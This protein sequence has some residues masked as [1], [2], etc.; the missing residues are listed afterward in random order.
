MD[1]KVSESASDRVIRVRSTLPIGLSLDEVDRIY[2]GIYDDHNFTFVLHRRVEDKEVEGTN[3]CLVQVSKPSDGELAIEA[4]AD[5]R[6]RGGA[7]EALHLMNL[8][9]GLHEKTGLELKA[10]VF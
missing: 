9:L 7:G 8:L 3:K 1:I 4:V 10:S 2:E 6:L 5:G